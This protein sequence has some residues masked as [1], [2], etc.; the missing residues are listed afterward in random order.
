M[1]VLEN[2]GLVGEAHK[3]TDDITNKEHKMPLWLSTLEKDAT[4]VGD[5]TRLFGEENANVESREQ[6]VIREAKKKKKSSLSTLLGHL[7]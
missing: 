7:Q 5:Q 4:R 2:C 3:Y 1:L 6:L